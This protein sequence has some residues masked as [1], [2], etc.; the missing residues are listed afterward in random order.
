MEKT[1]LSAKISSIYTKEIANTKTGEIRNQAV[2]VLEK[3][4]HIK[5][6]SDKYAKIEREDGKIIQFCYNTDDSHRIVITSKGAEKLAQSA[7]ILASQLP[8]LAPGSTISFVVALAEVGDTYEDKDGNQH[9]IA[10]THATIGNSKLILTEEAK[11]IALRVAAYQAPVMSIVK[12]DNPEKNIE[13]ELLI[14]NKE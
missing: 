14:N 9:E 5:A 6:L 13:D 7:G 4:K 3:N 1:I 8:I 10:V 12:N 2:V 11:L